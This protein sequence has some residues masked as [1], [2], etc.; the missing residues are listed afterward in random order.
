MP[1]NH[2]GVQSCDIYYTG[3]GGVYVSGGS[4]KN[5]IPGGSFVE[6]CRIHDYNRRNKFLFAG[7]DVD[8]DGNRVAHNVIYNSG[9]EGIYVNG[10][11]HIFEYNIIHDV[12]MNSDDTSP[13]YTG[14]DPSSR[15]D[16]VRYNFFHHIGRKDRMVMGVYVDDG[17][18]DVQIYGNV[19]YK[20]ATYGTVYS[21]SGQDISVKNNMFISSYGPA[22]HLKSMFYDFAKNSV[23]EFFG[24]NG[25]YRN[26]LTKMVDIYKPPYSINLS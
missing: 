15:G 5:L 9:Y 11:N 26:S 18:C 24:K 17:S 23:D 19:F 7:I 14:R 8:G 25:I 13:W 20:V 2:Q 10:N 3:S 12:S 1:G 6:N 16:I 21:N 22:V 4:K